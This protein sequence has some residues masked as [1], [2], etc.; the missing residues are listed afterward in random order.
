MIAAD[1]LWSVIS[2]FV[3]ALSFS[4]DYISYP[5]V[6]AQ[7]TASVSGAVTGAGTVAMLY[8]ADASE[9]AHTAFRIGKAAAAWHISQCCALLLFA[10]IYIKIINTTN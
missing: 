9:G 10:I 1:R 2:N 5:W 6:H 8:L 7:H 4:V 3:I